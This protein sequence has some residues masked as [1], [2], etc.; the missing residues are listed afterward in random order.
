LNTCVLK[1]FLL[2]FTVDNWYY[3]F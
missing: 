2:Y 1:T 3:L